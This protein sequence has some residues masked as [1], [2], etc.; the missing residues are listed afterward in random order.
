MSIDYL[1]MLQQ[2]VAERENWRE[3][4]DEADRQA[5]RLD[6]LIRAT[7]K[8]LPLEQRAKGEIL[9]DRLDKRPP[10]LGMGI[11][12]CLSDP[13][14]HWLTPVEIRNYLFEIRFGLENYTS[15]PLTSIHTTLK[16]MVPDEIEV[17]QLASGSKAYRLK[18]G[19]PLNEARVQVAGVRDFVEWSKQMK[20]M[21][22]SMPTDS[23]GKK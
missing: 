3:R 4:R 16:R 17:K 19:V 22:S 10:G 6:A 21:F 15:N 8:M 18:R 5:L 13:K 23:P 12:L 11:R 7:A 2:L 1:Q 14:H 20:S 9:L